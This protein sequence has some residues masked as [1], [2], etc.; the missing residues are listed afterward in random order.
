MAGI[1]AAMVYLL[2][3]ILSNPGLISKLRSLAFQNQA[4]GS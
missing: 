3:F 1:L 2:I 4:A